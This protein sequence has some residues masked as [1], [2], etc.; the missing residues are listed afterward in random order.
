MKCKLK[1]SKAWKFAAINTRN[2]DI[3]FVMSGFL[4]HFTNVLYSMLVFCLRDINIVYAMLI[5]RLSDFNT[6]Y[7]MLKL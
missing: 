7:M 3:M 5:F 2:P 6:W 1:V 4:Y